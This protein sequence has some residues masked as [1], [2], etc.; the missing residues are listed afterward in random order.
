MAPGLGPAARIPTAAVLA[1]NPQPAYLPLGREALIQVPTDTRTPA[2]GLAAQTY[3]T[4]GTPGGTRPIGR[5]DIPVTLNRRF[6]PVALPGGNTLFGT[7]ESFEGTRGGYYESEDAGLWRTDGTAAGLVRIHPLPPMTPLVVVGGLAYYTA[8]PDLSCSLWRSDGTPAGT[9]PLPPQTGVRSLQGLVTVA[10]LGTQVVVVRHSWA[11]PEPD[12]SIVAFDPATGT[13]QTLRQPLDGVPWSTVCTVQTFCDRT[14]FLATAGG[15]LFLAAKQTGPLLTGRGRF[16][17]LATDGT[18]GGTI[19]LRSFDAPDT[20]FT[21]RQIAA[22]GPRVLL[23][24]STEPVAGGAPAHQLWASDGTPAG[25]VLLR[26]DSGSASASLVAGDGVVFVVLP[27]G[28][29]RSDGTPGG[30]VSLDTGTIS[31]VGTVGGRLLYS[32]CQGLSCALRAVAAGAAP[33][34]LIAAGERRFGPGALAGDAL[35]FA[36]CDTTAGCEPWRSD[37]T[38]GGTA[39]TADVAPGT[40]ASFERV[41]AGAYAPPNVVSLGSRVL[42]TLNDGAGWTT[43]GSDGSAQGTRRLLDLGSRPAPPSVDTL[44]ALGSRAYF[45]DSRHN[46]VWSSDGTAEGT[47]PLRDRFGVL[48]PILPSTLW[49]G[50]AVASSQEGS[51]VLIAP[52]GAI[53]ERP[54][55]G[56]GAI[57]LLGAAGGKLFVA[58]TRAALGRYVTDVYAGDGTLAGSVKVLEGLAGTPLLTEVGGRALLTISRQYG[59]S[60]LALSD[61]TPG[62][63]RELQTP[64]QVGGGPT[65]VVAGGRLVVA[66]LSGQDRAL[67]AL[68]SAGSPTQLTPYE[69]VFWLTG[70]SDGERAF[71]MRGNDPWVTDGTPAGTRQL[72]AP[73]EALYV[74][75]GWPA[76]GGVFL[77]FPLPQGVNQLWFDA[78]GAP[79]R[80]LLGAAPSLKLLTVAGS[81]LLLRVGEELW[82]S[83][84]T[85]AGTVPLQRLAV[86]SAVVAQDG[87]VFLVGDT[88][89]GAAALYTIAPGVALLGGGR[90]TAAPGET[91]SLALTVGYGATVA[92]GAAG[93]VNL[94]V[95]LPPGLAYRGNNA[96]LIPD[97][98]VPPPGGWGGGDAVSFDLPEPGG[99]FS[100]RTIV[101]RLGVAE[102]LPLGTRLG[103]RAETSGPAGEAVY[104]DTVVVGRVLL[105]PFLAR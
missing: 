50:S 103:V 24:V 54:W 15:R 57:G 40:A 42:M 3:V 102:S 34:T 32:A 26:T 101:I 48:L 36:G 43:W 94:R 71:L 92:P 12:S 37:G 87:R 64:A 20:S 21:L 66:G 29:L 31:A 82:Q 99:P 104:S 10:A 79:P 96:G 35:I 38:A 86:D 73:S 28:L 91:V 7:G 93:E 83:D 76:V 77:Q 45:V 69:N 59:D 105:L 19:D 11:A 75:G 33:E 55:G 18:P 6:P 85:A 39:R 22:V 88:N 90:L 89:A 67:F 5:A 95:Y 41:P 1:T 14:A 2:G 100:A 84:G 4:D 9:V 53:T 13:A 70:R 27:G 16:T 63:T 72:S 44:V 97:D 17:L 56:P 51:L 65:P 30:T 78:A 74:A 23:S 61:G 68:D 49:N 62:G 98:L 47:V 52:D 58:V 60:R 25:T 80:L 81:R 8:C 46:A